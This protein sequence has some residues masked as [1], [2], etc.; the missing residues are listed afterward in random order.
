MTDPPPGIMLRGRTRELEAVTNL[1]DAAAQGNGG[2]LLF[3]GPAGLGKTA[4]VDAAVKTACERGAAVV[5]VT[6]WPS[7]ARW[8]FAGLQR[9]LPEIGRSN[10]QAAA[11][12]GVLTRDLEAGEHEPADQIALSMA[13]VARW[14]AGASGV[15]LL[16][17]I[18]DA[19]WLD[20]ES[21]EVLSLAPH[22]VSGEPIAMVFAARLPGGA[23][24]LSSIPAIQL[25]ELDESASR[26]V[27]ADVAAVALA[28]DVA[29]GLTAIAGGNP[30]PWSTWARRCRRNNAGA[31]CR[32]RSPCRGT[33]G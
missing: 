16:C 6:G 26:A 29:N 3:T 12:A 11:E 23:D 14:R 22:R 28:D 15:P 4:V 5:R 10:G 27:L 24:L 2:A 21:L 33:A 31:T 19:Q 30:R 18:D 7:E 13:V 20:R 25:N 1:L 8:R 32:R 9:M 17:C